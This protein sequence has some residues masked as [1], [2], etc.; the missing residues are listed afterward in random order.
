MRARL[1]SAIP[2]V[3]PVAGF[4]L[5]LALGAALPAIRDVLNLSLP[6]FGLIGIGYVCGKLMRFPEAHLAWMN[7][8]IVYVALPALFIN[9]ISVTPFEQLGNWPF[10]AATTVSTYIAFALAFVA[11]AVFTQGN[12][13]EATIAGVGGAYS[14]IGYLG[15]GLTLAALGPASTVPTALIFVFDS[16]LLFALTP[17]LMALAG[18]EKA[19]VGKTARLVA[20]RIVSH[21][22]NIATAI[23]VAM[24]YFQAQ[25]PAPVARMLTFLQ[26]GAAPAAL[27]VMG[28]TIALREVK[29]LAPELPVILLIKLV[30]HPLIV[31]SLLS[32]VGDFGRDWTFTAVLMAAL[33][34]ALN[35]FVMAN[36][37]RCYVERA[38]STIL[39]GTLA[40]IVTLTALLYAIAS[41][42]VPYRLFQN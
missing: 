17:F 4:L 30:L 8:F 32:I 25:P 10:V 39:L 7:F 14:N 13:R 11:G 40:S 29:R 41:G 26:N 23:G 18:Q 3:A 6:F 37:Y 21:P 31:W 36:Q 16:I 2:I 27:F 20:W 12:L 5:L 19:G 1:R 33:P 22:F 9:L 38:S 34:P 24:A 15:P 28:V 42:A 35:V